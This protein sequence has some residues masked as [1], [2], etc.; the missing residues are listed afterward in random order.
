[1]FR[2]WFGTMGGR[3]AC[4]VLFGVFYVWWFRKNAATVPVRGDLLLAALF[5]LSPV[6]N[7]WYLV[8]MA[9][10]VALYPSAWGITA[11]TTVLL[12]YCTATNLQLT[13]MGGFDHPWWVRP[14]EI[15]PVLIA[16]AIEKRLP[17]KG[18]PSPSLTSA[19]S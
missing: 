2:D 15:A 17:G 12:A 8:L 9:P 5:L 18:S 6:V 13:G 1:L 4:T 14:L 7:P 11:L 16:A 10:F 19:A 3:V